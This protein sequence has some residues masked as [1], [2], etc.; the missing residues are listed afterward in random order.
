ML[1]Y[2]LVFDGSLRRSYAGDG[3]TEGGAADVVHSELGAELHGAGLTTVFATD[4]DF[5]F[6]TGCAAF[7]DTHFHE[8]P[9]TFLVEDFEGVGLDYAV[10]LVELEELGSV[11][12]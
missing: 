8:L 12:A 7:L 10:F 6:G 11:V 4:A 1:R 9:N 5:E 3:H 2:V